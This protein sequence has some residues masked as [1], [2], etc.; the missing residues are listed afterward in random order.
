[1]S[2]WPP[3]QRAS[4]SPYGSTNQRSIF[5]PGRVAIETLDGVALVE[6]RA[7]RDQLHTF[8]R[9]GEDSLLRI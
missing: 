2:I 8:W 3:E 1:M 6:R 4:V 5:T 7:P 9:E